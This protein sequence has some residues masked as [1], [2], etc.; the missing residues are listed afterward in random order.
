MESAEI[1]AEITTS[2]EENEEQMIIKSTNEQHSNDNKF[3]KI[4]NNFLESDSD[5]EPDNDQQFTEESAQIC[6]EQ[7]RSCKPKRIIVD[8]DSENEDNCNQEPIDKAA[9]LTKLNSAIIES[10]C[11]NEYEVQLDIQDKIEK[12]LNSRVVEKDDIE[13]GS[14]E[15]I[16]VFTETNNIRIAASDSEEDLNEEL[17]P[18][19]VHSDSTKGSKKRVVN[20]DSENEDSNNS[21]DDLQNDDLGHLGEEQT[22]EENYENSSIRKPVCLI[23]YLLNLL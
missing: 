22:F 1:N 2:S 4:K 21:E 9:V 8:S 12:D 17:A 6:D 14:N 7:P 16:N 18:K 5:N 19:V 13:S 11:E 20:S 10:D 15:N 3:K 23:F